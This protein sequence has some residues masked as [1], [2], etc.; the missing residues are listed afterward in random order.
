MCVS[1]NLRVKSWTAIV[2]VC[3]CSEI[4]E[5]LLWPGGALTQ[6]VTNC[7]CYLRRAVHVWEVLGT[8]TRAD[9]NMGAFFSQL[10]GGQQG[11]F[12]FVF[13]FMMDMMEWVMSGVTRG[14]WQRRRWIQE[15]KKWN[16]MDTVCSTVYKDYQPYIISKSASREKKRQPSQ[17]SYQTWLRGVIPSSSS[18]SSLSPATAQVS[19]F[20]ASSSARHQTVTATLLSFLKQ[21]M[22]WVIAEWMYLSWKR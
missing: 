20:L 14:G 5:V 6:S 18:A 22:R 4:T 12:C 15:N 17:L 13:Q 8:E 7:S 3:V 10:G 2:C 11:L 19:Y 21:S 9:E 1:G 16:S